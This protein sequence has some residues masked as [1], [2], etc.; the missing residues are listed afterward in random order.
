MRRQFTKYHTN[1]TGN[2]AKWPAD[3]ADMQGIS[4]QNGKMRYLDHLTVI[5]V[6]SKFAWAFPVHCKDAKAIR[7]AFGQI[8]T[9]V[10]PRHQRRLQTD[11]NKEFFNS[12]FLTLIRRHGIQQFASEI[13]QKAVVVERFSRTIK[14]KIWIYLSDSGT[15]R[16]VHVIQELVDAY[17][18]SRH[19]T[20]GMAPG[21]V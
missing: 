5:D 15:V 2:N 18:H 3:L 11:K 19:R 10:N 21:D 4:R 1:V 9:I 13:E 20:I 17:N 7:E 12:D 14:T 6:F 16:W 8:L